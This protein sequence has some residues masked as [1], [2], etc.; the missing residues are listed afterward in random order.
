[1][2]ERLTFSRQTT[3]MAQPGAPSGLVAV[4]VA[5]QNPAEFPE[6]HPDAAEYARELWAAAH[7]YDGID[8]DKTGA[9]PEV[10]LARDRYPPQFGVLSGELRQGLLWRSAEGCH[11]KVP[12]RGALGVYR[13]IPLPPDGGH[14]L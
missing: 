11:Q 7:K 5:V 10:N 13:G 4:H 14:E 2:A 1:M 6:P 3:R 9:R 12:S 8:W